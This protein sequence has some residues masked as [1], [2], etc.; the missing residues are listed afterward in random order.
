MQ[1]PFFLRRTGWSLFILLLFA[2]TLLLLTPPQPAAANAAPPP[3]MIWF[4]FDDTEPDLERQGMQ[5][6]HC[7]DSTCTEA[8]VWQQYG[9]CEGS[10]CLTPDNE[11]PDDKPLTCRADRCM[12]MYG[13]GG[14]SDVYD[15]RLVVQYSDQVRQSNVF[16][17]V[18]SSRPWSR[19]ESNL[20]VS[21]TG[22]SLNVVVD[23][24]GN[25]APPPMLIAFLLTQA[26][27]LLVAGVFLQRLGLAGRELRLMLGLIA[28][29]NTLS[30]PVVWTFFPSLGFFHTENERE[31]G[32][33]MLSVALFYGAILGGFRW[34]GSRRW[35]RAL[36]IVAAIT[37]PLAALISLGR[38]FTIGYS[39]SPPIADGLPYG[40]TVAL[41]E[42]F[43]FAFETAL[44]YL[45]GRRRLSLG[46]AALLSLLMNLA[47]FL[48]GLLLWQL[49]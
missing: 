39:A 11:L 37:I 10:G 35:R 22:D 41:S 3:T 34:I 24:P 19:Y 17:S 7:K 14:F 30:F 33:H 13:Y 45:A 28:L 44:I 26:L 31:F 38:L 27:E 18:N 8:T 21:T 5:L 4:R 40:L 36:G 43:A 29:I 16:P 32:N 9:V 42:L 49:F 48:A 1:A 2:A 25:D 23:P 46:Q 12:Y 47:S 20:L 6:L 15:L